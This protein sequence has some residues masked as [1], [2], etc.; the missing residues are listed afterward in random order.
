MV[1]SPAAT[2]A[3]STRSRVIAAVLAAVLGV[4]FAGV[5]TVSH[6]I[7]VT[8]W[9]LTLYVGLFLSLVA[10]AAITLACRLLLPGRLPSYLLAAGVII[11]IA[12]FSAESV[13][14]SIL[15]PNGVPGQVWVIGPALLTVV[16]AAWP[17]VPST[18]QRPA[19]RSVGGSEA[20]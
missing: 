2:E 13:G 5:G 19:L 12:L 11:P 20:A 16:V 14:G 18:R 8:V 15:I 9:G 17:R 10:I 4:V 7:T 3:P 1:S 6:Q